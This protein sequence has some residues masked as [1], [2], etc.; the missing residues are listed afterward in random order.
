M[1][2]LYIKFIDKFGKEGTIRH[3]GGQGAAIAAI[4]LAQGGAI[5]KV[6]V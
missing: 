2:G 6:G 1:K 5:T 3:T 4:I